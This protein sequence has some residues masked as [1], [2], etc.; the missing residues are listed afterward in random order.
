MEN[1]FILDGQISASSY[2]SADFL[3][4]YGRLHSTTKAGSWSPLTCDSTQWLQIDVFGT[5]G[6]HI[7][8]TRVATQGR[9]V[10]SYKQWVTEYKLQYGNDELNFQNYKE[11]R[12]TEDKVRQI[13]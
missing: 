5:N 1:G 4:Y 13:K 8:V 3:P 6:R 9:A 11:R 10:E 2:W 12:Q 7:R